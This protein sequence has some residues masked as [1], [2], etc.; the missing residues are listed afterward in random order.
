MILK[1]EH[2]ITYNLLF[3]LKENVIKNNVL[4]LDF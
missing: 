3:D 1:F 4:R 2:N